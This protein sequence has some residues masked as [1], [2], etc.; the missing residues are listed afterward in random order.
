MKSLLIEYS[1]FVTILN[2]FISKFF[3]NFYSGNQNGDLNPLKKLETLAININ[4][5]LI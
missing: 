1:S 5:I 3:L 4:F 2:F